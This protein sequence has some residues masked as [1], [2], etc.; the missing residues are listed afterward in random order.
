[1]FWLAQFGRAC[2]TLSLANYN[3][4]PLMVEQKWHGSTKGGHCLI[5]W[6][7][8]TDCKGL[9]SL[10]LRAPLY[11]LGLSSPTQW[12]GTCWVDLGQLWCC[13]WVGNRS[14]WLSRRQGICCPLKNLGGWEHDILQWDPSQKSTESVLKRESLKETHGMWNAKPNLVWKGCVW[15]VVHF[16]GEDAQVQNTHILKILTVFRISPYTIKEQLP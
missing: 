8:L 5:G 11:Q 7:F 12:P 16:Q 10:G 15:E 1:M 6:G 9:A 3:Q 4:T 14:A 2:W 13:E